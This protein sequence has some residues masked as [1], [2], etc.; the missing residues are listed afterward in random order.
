ME[1]LPHSF[2]LVMLTLVL[3]NGTP[4]TGFTF[5]ACLQLFGILVFGGGGSKSFFVISL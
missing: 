3:S 1:D 2:S 5:F 4:V